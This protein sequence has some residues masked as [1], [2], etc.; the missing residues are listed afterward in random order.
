MIQ[1]YQ[2]ELLVIVEALKEC[3]GMLWCQ[4]IVVYTDH[5]HL[6]QDALGLTSNRVYRWRLIIQENGPKIIYIKGKDNTVA[7]AIPRLDFSP[8]A[9]PETYKKN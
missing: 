5:K 4:Q 9:H 3:K 2:I 8:K 6:M 7:D 1:R